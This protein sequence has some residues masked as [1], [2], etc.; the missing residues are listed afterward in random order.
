MNA[1]YICL[2]SINVSKLHVIL[3][4]VACLIG[5]LT[6]YARISSFISTSSPFASAS[7]LRP[8]ASR[9]IVLLALL[10]TLPQHAY[11]ISVSS[12]SLSGDL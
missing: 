10:H 12:Q 11:C 2:P 1:G 9:E 6:E 8:V 4:V 7:N 3:T 5:D